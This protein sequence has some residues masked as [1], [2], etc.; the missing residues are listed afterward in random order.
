MDSITHT[1]FGLTIYGATNK[2]NMPKELKKSL[3][4]AAV[5]GSLIPDIDVVSQLWD[6]EGMYQMWHRGITHS[7]FFIPVWAI[8]IWLFCFWIWKTKDRRILYIAALSVFIHNTSD[9]LNAWGTGYFEPF[10]DTRIS[11][12]I[13]PIVDLVI[14]A[15]ML[16]GYLSIRI[17]KAT[18]HKVYKI[19][20]IFI[21][22]HIMIQG[23][24]GY[25]VYQSTAPYYEQQVLTANFIPGHFKIV[26]KNGAEIEVLQLTAW[27]E[28][29]LVQQITS[30]EEAPLDVL[31]AENPYAKT[32]YQWS[33]FVVIVDD[34]E[35]I[36]IYDPRFFRFD[37]PF[38]FEYIKKEN[39]S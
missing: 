27:G 22:A 36:G 6:T 7:I 3:F 26:G 33:P 17:K 9:I 32:L 35:K 39:G 4:V 34:E 16:V 18:P 11:F 2:D 13:I 30:N 12:G 8:L 5:G 19:V 21:I 28:P 25:I 37:E 15:I 24:Q 1:L 29:Q 14:W 23:I 10:S 38:L 20:W 31:F